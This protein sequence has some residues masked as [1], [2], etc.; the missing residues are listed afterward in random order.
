MRQS[1]PSTLATALCLGLF[2]STVWSDATLTIKCD[3][4]LVCVTEG[5]EQ[6]GAVPAPESPVFKKQ[7]RFLIG[8]APEHQVPAGA[9]GQ[10]CWVQDSDGVT[11]LYRCGP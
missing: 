2:S 5:Y 3:K 6:S 11:R 10:H 4:D 7:K 9:V 1:I 8:I